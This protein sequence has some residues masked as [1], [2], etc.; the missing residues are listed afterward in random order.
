MYDCALLKNRCFLG[1]L[2]TIFLL[3]F[4]FNSPSAIVKNI[5]NPGKYSKNYCFAC[6]TITGS[7]KMHPTFPVGNEFVY[8][9]HNES[10]CI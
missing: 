10:I 5:Q 1:R 8:N 6:R 4:L 3:F 7:V 9:K 2:F